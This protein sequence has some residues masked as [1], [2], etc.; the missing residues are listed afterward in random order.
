MNV[1]L[2]EKIWMWGVGMV[3]AGFFATTA[4]SAVVKGIHPPSHI[5]TINPKTVMQDDRFRTQGVWL[6]EDG[7]VH[8]TV[9]GL[10]FTWL[11]TSLTLPADTPI[12]FH[13]TSMDVIHGYQIIRTNGQVMVVP[14]YVSQ[15]T[16]T[17]PHTGDY[18][19]ACNEY[20]GVGHHQ[21]AST[22][23]VVPASEWVGPGETKQSPFLDSGAGHA[24]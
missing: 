21:M 13:L 2:Y 6:D 12:T 14:G 23:T 15:F 16:T 7:D 10:M 19:V 9:V 20:C 5:E 18:L 4:Y 3:L 8:V 17:F 11:P 24:H 22:M 1:D